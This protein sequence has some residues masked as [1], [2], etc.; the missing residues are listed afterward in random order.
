[1]EVKTSIHR[2]STQECLDD[3]VWKHSA[4]LVFIRFGFGL[5]PPWRMPQEY[6]RHFSELLIGGEILYDYI[7][8]AMK[9]PLTARAFLLCQANLH[10]GV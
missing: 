3:L 10:A 4:G 8:S 2:I 9:S 1:M 7:V 6:M 5:E